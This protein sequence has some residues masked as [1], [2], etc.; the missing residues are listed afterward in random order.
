V[1]NFA[2]GPNVTSFKDPTTFPAPGSAGT[3][4]IPILYSAANNALIVAR[5][6]AVLDG[7][8]LSALSAVI[9]LANNLTISNCLYDHSSQSPSGDIHIPYPYSGV[10]IK[11]STLKSVTLGYGSGTGV[12]ALLNNI[13]TN[14]TVTVSS[15]GQISTVNNQIT[16]GAGALAGLSN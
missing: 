9:I 15:G 11:N 6:N 14:V 2:R 12:L 1:Q 8:D 4:N 3:P 13:L 10:T 5:D 16:G 7:Y